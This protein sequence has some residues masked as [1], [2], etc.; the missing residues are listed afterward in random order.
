MLPV[1]RE[2]HSSSSEAIKLTYLADDED[3]PFL[4][5]LHC[6]TSNYSRTFL[7]TKTYM[8]FPSPSSVQELLKQLEQVETGRYSR[9]KCPDTLIIVADIHELYQWR[10][11]L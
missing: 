11:L 10:R 6:N 4:C 3:N 9:R 8:S 5:T 1:D 2:L 7:Y